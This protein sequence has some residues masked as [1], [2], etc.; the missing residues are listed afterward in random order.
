MTTMKR[1][2]R[3]KTKITILEVQLEETPKMTTME[4]ELLQ[5]DKKILKIGHMM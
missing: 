3:K 5:E 1:E 4:E 2:G